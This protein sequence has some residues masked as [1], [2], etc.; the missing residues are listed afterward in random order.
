M[1]SID[2]PKLISLKTQQINAPDIELEVLKKTLQSIDIRQRMGFYHFEKWM[3]IKDE[4]T[5]VFLANKINE[6]P[7]RIDAPRFNAE[8]FGF[9][10]NLHAVCDSFPFVLNLLINK[11]DIEN[12]SVSW[13][14]DFIKKYVS[15]SLESPI[16]VNGQITTKTF[17]DALVS[18]QKNEYFSQLKGVVNRIKHKYLIPIMYDRGSIYFEEYSYKS[19]LDQDQ[20]LD[21]AKQKTSNFENQN[22][23]KFMIDCHDRLWPDLCDLFDLLIAEL[24]FDQG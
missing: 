18:F 3:E 22:V 10:Q 14:E 19:Y 2:S 12:P 15:L 1:K 7:A 21:K 17:F 11:I 24:E 23:E 6:T 20:V 4:K 9:L 13:G 5:S 8:V 16:N